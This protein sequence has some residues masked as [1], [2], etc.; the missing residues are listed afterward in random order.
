MFHFIYIDFSSLAAEAVLSLP[1]Y[2]ANGVIIGV[3]DLIR[4]A[5]KPKF[6]IEE[7]EIASSY[8]SWSSVALGCDWSV[9]TKLKT[10]INRI[11]Q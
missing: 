2:L 9:E 4:L 1:L 6:N 10:S 7:E 11:T 5:G 8:L 3:L